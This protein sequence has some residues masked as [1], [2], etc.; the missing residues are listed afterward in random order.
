MASRLRLCSRVL[1]TLLL[2]MGADR[3]VPRAGT[4]V[5]NV[6]RPRCMRGLKNV[7][8]QCNPTAPLTL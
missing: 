1:A 7:E 6:R 3:N 2:S 5:L 4:L 8:R